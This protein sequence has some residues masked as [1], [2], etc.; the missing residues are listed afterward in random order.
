MQ[1]V[2]IIGAGPTGLFGAF[3]ATLRN[4]SWSIVD[5]LSFAGGQLNLL[6][7]EKY[8]YDVPGFTKIKAK[9]LVEQ[10]LNQ[11]KNLYKSDLPIYFE[12]EVIDIIKIDNGYKVITNKNEF[13]TKTIIIAHGGGGFVPQKLKNSENYNNIDY[14]ITDPKP[15]SGK[16]VCVLGGGDSALDYANM[17]ADH[18]AT[19][20]LVHRREQFRA[21][22][23]SIDEFK[24]KGIIYAP[25]LVEDV[26]GS[27]NEINKLVLKHKD[28][29]TLIDLE[30]DHLIVNYG[31]VLTKNY[32]PKWNID[33]EKGLIKVSSKME[34]SVAGIYAA[35]NGVTYPGKIKLIVSGH[36]EIAIAIYE[37]NNLLNPNRASNTEHSTNMFD[38]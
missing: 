33:S 1:D 7:P 11:I 8:I 15:Y 13:M 18:G 19:V 27:D 25:Y 36:A 14:F 24:S 16:R 30:I 20:S 26:T 10:Q 23:S 9:D 37:I 3:L 21:F 17:L 6:Y 35:G 34:T 32:L 28:D 5:S 12:N 29:K 38:E 4:L 31:F 22:E 2:L